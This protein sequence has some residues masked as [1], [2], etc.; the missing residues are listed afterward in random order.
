MEKYEPFGHI[1]TPPASS[2]EQTALYTARSDWERLRDYWQITMYQTQPATRLPVELPTV[3]LTP[4]PEDVARSQMDM[5]D[6]LDLAEARAALAEVAQE[7]TIPLSEVES[8][9]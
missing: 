1:H 9:L 3:V 8:R 4:R 2:G 6:V 7:G 5:E